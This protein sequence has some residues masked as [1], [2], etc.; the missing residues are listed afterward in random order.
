MAS[1]RYRGFKRLK[2][3]VQ[4]VSR[5]KKHQ[6]LHLN[7]GFRVLIPHASWTNHFDGRADDYLGRHVEVRGW[8]FK[9]HGVSGM[10]IYHPSMLVTT[11]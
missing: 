5:S 10:K 11:D 3:S 4:R 8:I 6:V 2:G 1:K 7:G 9:T